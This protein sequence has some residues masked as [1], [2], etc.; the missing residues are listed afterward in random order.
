MD[1]VPGFFTSDVMSV[2]MMEE[3]GTVLGAVQFVNRLPRRSFDEACVSNAR[4]AAT[5][6]KMLL[7]NST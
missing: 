5:L 1:V 4:V 3:D 6:C 7:I 2:P